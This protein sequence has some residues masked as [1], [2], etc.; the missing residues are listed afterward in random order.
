MQDYGPL[1]DE[2]ARRVSEL[3]AA[4]GLPCIAASADISSTE[5]VRDS[6]GQPFAETLFHWVDPEL[7]YWNDHR[8]ALTAPFVTALRY[9][10]EP[11]YFHD[12][13]FASWRPSPR[14][15]AIDVRSPETAAIGS[16][17][18]APVYLPAGVV[19]G[20]VWASPDRRPDTPT[21]YARWSADLQNVALRFLALCHDV[22]APAPK[23]AQLTRREVQCL[24]WAAS[25]KS[26]GEIAQIVGISMPTVRFHVRNAAAKLGAPGRAQAI[27]RAATLGYIGR[28]RSLSHEA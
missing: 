5:P 13:C 19:G 22:S 18:V 8:F 21:T 17:I 26:D 6:R 10:S 24:K 4:I 16:A 25:G 3:G 27:H 15:S 1:L 23:P 14:L 20:V 11:F 2:A 7:K 28:V 12:G 9:T